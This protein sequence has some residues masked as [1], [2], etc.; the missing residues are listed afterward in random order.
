[1]SFKETIRKSHSVGSNLLNGEG[2]LEPENDVLQ[3]ETPS[4]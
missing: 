2:D 4:E 1:M 3:I